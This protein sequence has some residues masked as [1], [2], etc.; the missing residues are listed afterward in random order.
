MKTTPSLEKAESYLNLNI[1]SLSGAKDPP[2]SLPFIT[3]SRESGAGASSLANLTAQRLNQSLRP[4]QTRWRIFDGN[5]VEAMLKNLRYPN[6]IA[7]F[8]PEDAI[9]EIDAF[10]GELLG[11]HPNLWQLEQKTHEI[12]RQ[13]AQ[14]GNC[15]SD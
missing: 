12:I 1:S 5:L 14:R 9:S 11:R 4:G 10:M 6:R 7:Q 2:Q 13:I 3:L 15:T 8:M